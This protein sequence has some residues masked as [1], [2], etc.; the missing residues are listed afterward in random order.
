MVHIIDLSSGGEEVSL[1]GKTLEPGSPGHAAPSWLCITTFWQTIG[2]G[3]GSK[4]TYA[5]EGISLKEFADAV[6]CRHATVVAAFAVSGIARNPS[7]RY[8]KEL[9][10]RKVLKL[11]PPAGYLSRAEA[12]HDI[13]HDHH[14]EFIEGE[15]DCPDF[16]VGTHGFYAPERVAAVKH[17]VLERAAELRK[18]LAASRHR[19]PSRTFIYG[20]GEAPE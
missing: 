13:G 8:S 16:L 11:L 4:P 6:H 1:K 2:N 5:E 10:E 17:K 3:G 9:L 19:A 20:K 12:R 14:A 15:L 7:H 18:E